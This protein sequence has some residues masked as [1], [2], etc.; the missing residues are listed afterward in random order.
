MELS[1]NV[2]TEIPSTRKVAITQTP[3]QMAREQSSDRGVTVA[4][5]RFGRGASAPPPHLPSG[6]N[7]L[8][9]DINLSAYFYFF[10]IY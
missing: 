8:V 6:S 10:H 4:R 2:R 7:N 3:L 1:S 5:G 9:V